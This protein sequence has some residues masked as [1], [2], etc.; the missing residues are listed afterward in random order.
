M[1]AQEEY[2][3]AAK[4]VKRSLQKDKETYISSLAEKA[5]K[6]ANNGQM[7]TLYQTTKTLSGKVSISEVPVKDKDG[8]TVFEKEDQKKRWV[9]HFEELLNR[10]PPTDPPDIILARKDVPIYCNPPTRKKLRR[11]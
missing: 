5:E 7:R 8:K 4:E 10:P 6:A 9:E 3:H 2:N 1:K 11:L